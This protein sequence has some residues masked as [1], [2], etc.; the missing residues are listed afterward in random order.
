[1]TRRSFPIA[2]DSTGVADF[3]RLHS[4]KHDRQ[5]IYS[6]DLLELVGL[7]LRPLP[8]EN[9]SDLL[10]VARYTAHESLRPGRDAS[11]PAAHV[12]SGYSEGQG[13]TTC[14]ACDAKQRPTSNTISYGRKYAR[15][16][17]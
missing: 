12:G 2:A 1:M 11:R 9:R 7:N 10:P 17:Y 14:A 6:F 3:E 13:K 16:L 4:R 8:L 5:T 15:L